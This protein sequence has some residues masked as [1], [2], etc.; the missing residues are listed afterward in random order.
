MKKSFMFVMG[1]MTTLSLF[2]CNTIN[3]GKDGLINDDTV[4]N[5]SYENNIDNSGFNPEKIRNQ[6]AESRIQIANDAADRVTALND[7]KNANV[8][9][10]NHNAYVAAVLN[11]NTQ[12]NMTKDIE[13]KI[14]SE[15]NK[16]D[17]HINNVYVSTNPDF[18][19]RMNGF[20]NQLEAGHPVTSIIDE[21]NAV[22]REI[23]P[24]DQ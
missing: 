4:R 13:R 22:V 16:S 11:T 23:F 12:G 9:V 18:I 15:V 14:V 7:V 5:V 10:T 8:I 3:Q 6:Y 20:V 24:N 21:F 2:G 19:N 1:C 17:K